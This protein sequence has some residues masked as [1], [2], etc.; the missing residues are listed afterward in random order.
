MELLCHSRFTDVHEIE[1]K[2]LV[3]RPPHLLPPQE[4][5]NTREEQSGCRIE[6]KEDRQSTFQ[7]AVTHSTISQ[8]RASGGFQDSCKSFLFGSLEARTE[9]P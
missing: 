9:W 8:P 2:I 1:V 4:V 7:A 3:E 5:G 6:G